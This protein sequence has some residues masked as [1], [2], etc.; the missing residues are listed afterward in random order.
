LTDDYALDTY[1]S[2]VY[3]FIVEEKTERWRELCKQAGVEQDP[4][5]LMEL[6]R[7][8]NE[9]LLAKENRLKSR[10]KQ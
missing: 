10:D 8:I 3:I 4:E 5:K 2:Q 1:G 6:V 9:L 7:E